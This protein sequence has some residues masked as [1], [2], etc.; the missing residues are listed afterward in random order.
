[1]GPRTSGSLAKTHLNAKQELAAG[2]LLEEYFLQ[3]TQPEILKIDLERSKTFTPKNNQIIDATMSAIFHKHGALDTA[4]SSFPVLCSTKG[5]GLASPRQK[6]Q[7]SV[8][9]GDKLM[10]I[11][12]VTLAFHPFPIIRTLAHF[13]LFFQLL[14][15]RQKEIKAFV[16][17]SNRGNGPAVS[18]SR[19][20]PGQLQ[21]MLQLFA[22]NS[23]LWRQ[24]SLLSHSL[25]ILPF[26]HQSPCL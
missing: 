17:S 25:E 20:F 10:E 8:E 18:V 6:K 16:V 21:E 3:L 1:M 26:C 13:A 12:Q 4:L 5:K 15:K 14:T 19:L 23:T 24:A 2:D 9:D 11:Q 22:I 7:N